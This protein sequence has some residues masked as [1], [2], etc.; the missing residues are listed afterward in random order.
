MKIKPVIAEETGRETKWQRER[1]Q[2]GRRDAA[3]RKPGGLPESGFCAYPPLRRTSPAYPAARSWLCY[4]SRNHC[5]GSKTMPNLLLDAETEQ[6]LEARIVHVGEQAISFDR[7][8]DMAEGNFVELVQGVVVEKP[9]VQLDHE[10]CSIWLSAIIKAYSDKRRAGRVLSSRI[11]VRTDNFGGR[12]P[13]LLFVRQERLGI[14][15]TKYVNGAPDLIIEIVSPNDRPSDLRALEADYHRL[16]VPE[17]VFLDLQKQEVRLL[18]RHEAGYAKTGITEG[19]VTFAALPDLT[20]QAEWMLR[21][22]RPDVF[23]T[24]TALLTGAP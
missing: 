17:L 23:D 3:F 4:N 12:M 13:D 20:L 14:L 6:S 18:R 7:F 5:I 15:E 1:P 19:P 22:P 2:D 24:L 21:E 8:L 9:M 16:G 11:M 10:M